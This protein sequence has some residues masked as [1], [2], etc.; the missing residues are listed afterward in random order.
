MVQFLT[1]DKGEKIAVQIP[2]EEWEAISYKLR[3]LEQMETLKQGFQS[4][5]REWEQIKRGEKEF[6][7]LDDFLNA[8]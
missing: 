4:A 1:N 5:F 8:Q 7:T 2:I 3:H 6:I